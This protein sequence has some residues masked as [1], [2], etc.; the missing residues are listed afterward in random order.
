MMKGLGT[1]LRLCDWFGSE[2]VATVFEDVGMP[3]GTEK[4][5]LFLCSPANSSF[6]DVNCMCIHQNLFVAIVV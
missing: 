1:N 6:R 3:L 4:R 2:S 5:T